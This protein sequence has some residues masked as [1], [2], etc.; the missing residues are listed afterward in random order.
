MGNAVWLFFSL[1]MWYFSTITAPFASGVL[2]AVPALGIV[3]LVVGVVWG[4]IK[5]RLGL[6]IFLV[7]PVASQALMV[8][9][10]FMLYYNWKVTADPLLFP[11]ELNVQAYHSVPIFLWGTLR[12]PKHYENPQFQVFYNLFERQAVPRDWAQIKGNVLGKLTNAYKFFLGLALALPL[13]A[14]WPVFAR[15]RT[16]MLVFWEHMMPN[17]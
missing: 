14:L 8:V 10:G 3:S 15:A 6:M 7:L 1:P 16:R 17:G 2:T 5:R 13:V 4:A 12:P 11:H 9:A